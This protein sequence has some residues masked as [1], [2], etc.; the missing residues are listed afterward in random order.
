MTLEELKQ[1]NKIMHDLL[2]ELAEDACAKCEEKQCASCW[3]MDYLDLDNLNTAI[4][5]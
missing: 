4:T 5:F 3:C 1:D 2:Q